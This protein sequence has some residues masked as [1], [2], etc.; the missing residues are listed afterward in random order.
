MRS[1]RGRYV[2]AGLGNGLRIILFLFAC[3]LVTCEVLSNLVNR[4]KSTRCFKLI[5]ILCFQSSPQAGRGHNY[6]I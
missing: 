2:N 4:F 3:K 1:E 6:N 5:I